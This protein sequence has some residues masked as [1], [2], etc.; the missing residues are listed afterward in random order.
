MH[1]PD[2][3]LNNITLKFFPANTTAKSQPLDQGSIRAFKAHYR[4]Q[5]VQRII[6]NASSA[7]SVED[8]KINALDA[9]WWIDG[10]WKSVT[11]ATIQNTFKSSNWKFW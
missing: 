6:A 4:K 8:I 1:P 10:A 3:Q 11:E 9:I 7:Y 2:I 5:S